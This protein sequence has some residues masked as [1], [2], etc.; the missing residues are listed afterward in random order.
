M[1]CKG[2]I[3]WYYNISISV[4]I[5]DRLVEW[6]L[7]VQTKLFNRMVLGRPDGDC[8][9]APSSLPRCPRN[10]PAEIYNFLMECSSQRSL[11]ALALSNPKHTGL[12]GVNWGGGS[13]VKCQW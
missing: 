4:S 10:A 3:L 6:Y 1:S 11:G 9:V 5:K 7:R 2:S 12:V 8:L 13:L